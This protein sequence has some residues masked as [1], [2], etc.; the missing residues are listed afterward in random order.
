M[1]LPNDINLLKKLKLLMS[2]KYDLERPNMD[3]DMSFKITKY[4][5][6]T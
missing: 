5:E 2:L 6:N 1:T 4:I 3:T